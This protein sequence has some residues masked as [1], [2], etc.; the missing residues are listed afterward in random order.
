ML[1][2]LIFNRDQINLQNLQNDTGKR[3]ELILVDHH[4]LSSEDIALKPSVVAIIDH[5]PLDPAWSWNNVSLNI[6]IMGS[7]STLVARNVLQRNPDILDAQLSSLLR[8]ILH[9]KFLLI[10]N[11]NNLNYNM[12]IFFRSNI[13]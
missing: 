3:L 9:D 8:G 10:I 13:G 2:E 7:C 4:T 5:R 12:Y 6:E 11:L 1:F